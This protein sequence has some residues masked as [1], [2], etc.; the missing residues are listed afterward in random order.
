MLV[1]G[2]ILNRKVRYL[3]RRPSDLRPSEWAKGYDQLKEVKTNNNSLLVS[4]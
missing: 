4:E 2:C 1:A 3:V